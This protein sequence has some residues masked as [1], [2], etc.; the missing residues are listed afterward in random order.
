MGNRIPERSLLENIGILELR[1]WLG[2]VLFAKHGL[3]KIVHF[4]EMRQHFPDPL[5]VGPAIGFLCAFTA[6]AICSILILVG[7]F[8]RI[9]VLIVLINLAVVF[10]FMHNLSFAGD[11]AEV[12][13]LYLG[14]YLAILFLGP[15]RYSFDSLLYRQGR[16]QRW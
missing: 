14:G 11:H 8:T 6:D 4:N 15:G 16:V 3:E 2:V 9:A 12:V 7:L 5:H 10:Y 1:V 13:Y